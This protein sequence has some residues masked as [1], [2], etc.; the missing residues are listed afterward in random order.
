MFYNQ[1]FPVRI[2]ETC[3][4]SFQVLQ[5]AIWKS[6]ERAGN[7]VSALDAPGIGFQV[8]GKPNALLCLALL[9]FAL[10]GFALLCFALLWGL[11][12]R[13]NNFSHIDLR[14]DFFICFES[15]LAIIILT[16]DKYLGNREKVSLGGITLC[17]HTIHRTSFHRIF[18]KN[19]R[20]P[21]QSHLEVREKIW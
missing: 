18:T 15:L 17:N 13:W 16:Y 14:K 12:P 19:I 5:R 20:R 2:P 1:T 8:R 3:P 6:F 21:N 4:G 10:F 7:G 9:G 11:T